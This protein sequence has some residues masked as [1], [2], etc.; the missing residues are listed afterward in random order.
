[1]GCNLVASRNCGNWEICHPDLLADPCTSETFVACLARARARK[2][3]DHLHRFLERRSYDEL[4]KVLAALSRPLY[5][6]T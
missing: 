1:M 3:A 5:A 2:H 6:R 4:M